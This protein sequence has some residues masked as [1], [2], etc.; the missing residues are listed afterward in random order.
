MAIFKEAPIK[1]LTR[2]RDTAKANADRLAIKLTEAEQAVI[3]TKQAS[4]SAA[5][6]ADDSALDAAETAERAALHRHS[7]LSAA[8]GEADKML[9]FL[10][11]SIA[12][13]TDQKTRAATAASVNAL[14]DELVEAAAAYDASTAALAEVSQRALIVTMEANGLAVFTASSLIEVAVAVPIVAEHLRLYG[15]AVTNLQS[16][17]A[18]PTPAPPPVKPVPVVRE[19]LTQIF[20]TKAIKW[21]DQDGKQRSCGKCLDCELSPKA[22]A[23][24]LAIGAALPMD[25][26]ERKKSLGQWP[27]NYNLATA[28]DLDS[29]VEPA[30]PVVLHSAFEP[31]PGLPKPFQ[32][33]VATGGAS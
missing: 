19:Q 1:G 22:A 6:N 21:R 13:V 18:F 31:L 33:R 17:A 23:R 28:I 9:F 12:T 11:E 14:A 5:L 7:T 4:Q 27:S 15:R 3:A 26:P 24:A 20:T 8:K 16:P 32:L 30:G 2:D 25:H 29:D 10:E